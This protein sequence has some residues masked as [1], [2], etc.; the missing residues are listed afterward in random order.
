MQVQQQ[1]NVND[2]LFKRKVNLMTEG[3]PAVY[4]KLRIFN[5]LLFQEYISL[6]R[7]NF[8]LPYFK[9]ISIGIRT[10]FMTAIF[11]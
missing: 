6:R 5:F 11:M 3:L 7:F 1:E 4:Y 2:L 10:I 8:S 9:I